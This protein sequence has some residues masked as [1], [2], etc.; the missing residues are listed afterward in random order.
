[1]AFE[2]FVIERVL[3]ASPA[4][5]WQALTDTGQMQK[6][7]FD[8]PK[9]K[10][11]PGFEFEFTA[12]SDERQYRH[13]CKVTEAEP[14]RKLSYSWRYADYPGD[15]E[16]TFE[17]TPEGDKTRVRL[18]HKGLHTFPKD[19][20]DFKPES[21]QAGWTHILGKSLAEFVEQPY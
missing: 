7:Y 15:S 8:I 11:E 20:A 5:V 1:M 14:N 10:A 3:H 18:T 6:W 16:V 2:P 13:L 12:G 21:F 19:H 4:R 17:L 9:F